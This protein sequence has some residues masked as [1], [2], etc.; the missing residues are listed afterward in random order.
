MSP[1]NGHRPRTGSRN[2]PDVSTTATNPPGLRWPRAG[3]LEQARVILDAVDALPA[4]LVGPEL[5]A[6]AEQH[7]IGLGDLDGDTRL[8]PKALRIAGR[9]ILEVLAPEPPRR[10]RR[11]GLL[12]QPVGLSRFL[13]A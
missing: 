2:S 6:D 13:A 12:A 11:P 1:G 4:D 5:V 7:L 8:D 3:R 9:K 10:F